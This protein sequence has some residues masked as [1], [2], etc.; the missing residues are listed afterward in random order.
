MYFLTCSVLSFFFT[1]GFFNYQMT[2]TLSVADACLKSDGEKVSIILYDGRSYDVPIK[3]ISWFEGTKDK[4]IVNS[5]DEMG[6]TRR[7]LFD[8]S[9]KVRP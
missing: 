3:N 9:K 8:F 7:L 6:R 1:M 2:M 5:I 4:L